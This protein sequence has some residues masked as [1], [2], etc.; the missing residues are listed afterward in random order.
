M[1]KDVTEQVLYVLFCLYAFLVPFEHV[2]DIFFGIDTVLKPYRLMS[3]LI[4][5]IFFLQLLRKGLP[6]T[7]DIKEDVFLYAV[8]IYGIVISLFRLI[9][10]I[11]DIGFFRNDM[12]LS[13]LYLVTFAIFK[14]LAVNKDQLLRVFRYYVIGMTANAFFM[15]NSFFFLG[16]TSRDAGFMDNPNYAALGLVVSMTYLFLLRDLDSRRLQ[17]MLLGALS[18]FLLYVFITTGS[19]TGLILLILAVFVVFLMVSM[20]QKLRLMLAGGCMILLLLPHN[21]ETAQLGG[22][23]IL[24]NRVAQSV[25]SG[26]EDVRFVVWRGTFLALEEKGYLGMGIGQFKANFPL[27][28][29]EEADNQ[30]YRMVERDYFMGTHND[31]MGILTDYGLPGLC[32]YVIFLVLNF[33]KTGKKLLA[34]PSLRLLGILSPLQFIVLSCVVVFGMTAESFQNPLFWFLLMFATKSPTSGYPALATK[35]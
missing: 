26:E 29:A 31:F 17:R 35:R 32:F 19:R 25:N 11:F 21:L 4:A 20:R 3:I 8:F 14:S 2:L 22:P 12:M 13:G 28:F 27:L 24:I 7:R 1:I 18:I 23:L 16:N 33:R 10:G 34:A 5:G 15:F 9:T 6:L 30:I